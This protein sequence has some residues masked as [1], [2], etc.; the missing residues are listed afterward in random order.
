MTSKAVDV[1]SIDCTIKKSNTNKRTLPWLTEDQD[2]EHAKKH[3]AED[4]SSLTTVTN[5]DPSNPDRL[6]LQ[7]S[8]Q[9]T[10][11]EMPTEF[12]CVLKEREAELPALEQSKRART[13]SWVEEEGEPTQLRADRPVKAPVSYELWTCILGH[14][15]PEFLYETARHI[16]APLHTILMDHGEASEKVWRLSRLRT[17]GFDHPDSP[18]GLNERQYADL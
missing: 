14:C 2:D 15:E 10:M 8:T 13:D 12:Q 5:Q 1:E 9:T 11:R 18:T 3:K 4:G 17:Y 6:Q 16:P 7:G